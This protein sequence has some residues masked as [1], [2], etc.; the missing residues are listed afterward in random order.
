MVQE[1]VS[2]FVI[3]LLVEDHPGV[4]MK[5]TGMFARR[6]HNI[7]SFTGAPSEQKGLSRIVIKTEGTEEQ[8]EQIQ[9]QMHKLIEVVKVQ[10][11][12]PD[13]SVIRELA[14]IKLLIQDDLTHQKIL[15]M[16]EIYHGKIVDANL[17]QITMEI[18]GT[19][20]KIDAFLNIMRD[21]NVLKEVSRSGNVAI[22]RGTESIFLH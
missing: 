18:V 16:I 3:A 19:S 7:I 1:S 8:V 21:L 6:G 13:K 5:I 22:F 17:K 12:H 10:L 4:T 15:S 2:Q 11:M 14:L 9:K 20:E